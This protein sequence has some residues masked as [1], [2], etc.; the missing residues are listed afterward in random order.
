MSHFVSRQQNLFRRKTQGVGQTGFLKPPKRLICQRLLLSN[1][2]TRLAAM[3]FQQLHVG[4]R[5]AAVYRFAHVVNGE[6]GDLH[7]I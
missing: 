2:A 7:A 5:H 1:E 6:Q 3:L 4:D